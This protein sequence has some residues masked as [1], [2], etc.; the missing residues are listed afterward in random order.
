VWEKIKSWGKKPFRT[1]R[2]KLVFSFL[3]VV[4]VE[5]PR[6]SS[7]AS[8]WWGIRSLPRRTR[9]SST[10]SPPRG[11]STRKNSTA[12]RMWLNLTAKRISSSAR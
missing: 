7:S 11:S 3:L 10:T 5:G 6:P 2:S 9:K 8:A 12:S 4:L 1:L